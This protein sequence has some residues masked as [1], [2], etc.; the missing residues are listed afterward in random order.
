MIS[1]FDVF[2]GYAATCFVHIVAIL[3]TIIMIL[4]IR[5]KYTAVGSSHCR[6]GLDG[7]LANSES[8]Q[9]EKKLSCS[10]TCMHSLNCSRSSWIPGL[11]PQRMS[12]IRCATS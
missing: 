12:P 6:G 3:M 5:S 10:F 8:L 1:L 4:H 11:Y 7:A 2:W 9:G